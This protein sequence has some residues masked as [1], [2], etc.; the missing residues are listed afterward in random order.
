MVLLFT[1]TLYRGLHLKKSDAASC[2]RGV[3]TKVR[4]MPDPST[5]AL[6]VQPSCRSHRFWRSWASPYRCR[7]IW[8]DITELPVPS[9]TLSRRGIRPEWA[10]FSAVRRDS[11]DSNK[12]NIARAA[13]RS[14]YSVLPVG[15]NSPSMSAK[16]PPCV[17][18]RVSG[19]RTASSREPAWTQ[20]CWCRQR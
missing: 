15:R 14:K 18:P 11:G 6:I 19:H 12:E 2:A 20:T 17:A 8:M 10:W 1:C 4:I 5:D 3:S 9:A 16:Y 13:P 7:R